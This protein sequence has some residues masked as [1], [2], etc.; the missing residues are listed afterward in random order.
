MISKI[1]VFPREKTT[2]LMPQ[3][4]TANTKAVSRPPPYIQFWPP[5][6]PPPIPDAPN[7]AYTSSS[8]QIYA[9]IPLP[10]SDGSIKYTPCLCLECKL[11]REVYHRIFDPLRS[12]ARWLNERAGVVDEAGEKEEVYIRELKGEEREK[13]Y[14]M[15]I[16]KRRSR[17]QPLRRCYITMRDM[18]VMV[19]K[20][21]E[22]ILE[23][24]K[25]SN[26]SYRAEKKG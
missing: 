2:N 24:M 3:P 12:Q 1:S 13:W 4:P 14:K 11:P 19:L 21:L 18:V 5:T 17:L 10:P 9:P 23:W 25:E 26:P 16:S 22:F 7:L 8:T 15:L 20:K 6:S